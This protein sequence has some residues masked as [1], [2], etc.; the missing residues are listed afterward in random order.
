MKLNWEKYWYEFGGSILK[1]VGTA[2]AGWGGVNVAASQGVDVPTLNWKALG[3]FIMAAGVIPAVSSFW[4]K[5]PLPDIEETTVTVTTTKTKTPN[6]ETTAPGND[7]SG[8][9]H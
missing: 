6:E 9:G 5:T 1:H 7:G 2:L 8:S 4:Q 3:I